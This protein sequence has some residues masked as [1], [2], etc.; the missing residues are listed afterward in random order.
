MIQSTRTAAAH[1]N[2]DAL[3]RFRSPS[4]GGHVVST[5][6]VG[7]RAF[8]RPGEE[9]MNP[10]GAPV[11]GDAASVVVQMKSQGVLPNH[12]IVIHVVVKVLRHHLLCDGGEDEVA[13]QDCCCRR[14]SAN[15]PA[16]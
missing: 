4:S 9:D 1:C 6:A 15:T 14:P 3:T 13:E 2:P 8:S 11:I 12:D 5:R 16:K 7:W 10:I